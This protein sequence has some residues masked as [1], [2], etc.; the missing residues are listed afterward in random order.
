MDEFRTAITLLPLQMENREEQQYNIETHF[1]KINKAESIEAIFNL[2]NLRI[3]N[4]ISYQL[5]QHILHLYGDDEANGMMKQYVVALE[6][7]KRTTT[8][9]EFLSVQSKRRCPEIPDA[10]RQ[11]M[12]IVIFIHK[13]LTLES[14]LYDIDQF[15]LELAEWYSLPEFAVITAGIKP[16]SVTTVWLMT[17]PAVSVIQERIQRGDIQ[18]LLKH[19]IA[20]LRIDG[21]TFYPLSELI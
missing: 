17:L 11:E 1:P 15:R 19:D 21:R 12:T 4:Y 20:E 7:F 16:G 14:S 2:L 8:L 5:L 18:F 9:Q 10:L 13:K 3:W 6:M